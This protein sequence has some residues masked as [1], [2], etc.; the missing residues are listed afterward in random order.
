MSAFSFR[1][2]LIDWPARA[3][4]LGG[5]VAMLSL[6]AGCDSSNARLPSVGDV[7]TGVDN[8]RLAPVASGVNRPTFLAELP[9]SGG[10]L[11]VLEQRGQIRRIENGELAAEPFLDLGDRVY[12][13]GGEQ[14]LLGLAFHPSFEE[15]GRFFL[16]YSSN[17]VADAGIAP[18]D[19]VISELVR[20]PGALTADPASER[21]LLHVSQP[22]TN[23]NGGMLAFSPTDGFLYIGLGDGGS[24]GDPE[25]NGQN[26]GT[27]LGKMLRIDVDARDRGEYGIP[28]GN[29]T[30][31]G[32]LPEIWSYGWRNPWRFSFD[33]DNGDLYAADVGQYA[34]EEVDYEPSGQGGRNYGWNRLEGTQCFEPGTGCQR[35]GV[36]PPITEYR[37]ESGCS[38]TGGYVYRGQALPDLRG[39]YLYSDYCSGSFGALRVE[40][41]QL[42]GQRDITSIINPDAIQDITSF[43]VDAA[44]EMYVLSRNGT[45]YRIEG[46]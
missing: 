38:I 22:Y 31:G 23:H 2:C 26:M 46:S 44:G 10:V 16:H 45:V 30:G 36:T 39:I 7:G 43:G 29:M 20:N 13:R 17:A 1:V 3:R 42:V 18:G 19:G 33:A 25:G 34:I 35:S 37:H 5:A 28:N 15:N 12:S 21:R 27:W 4:V 41:G 32:A 6:V 24:G 14:G 11:L 8:L 9:G 40:G